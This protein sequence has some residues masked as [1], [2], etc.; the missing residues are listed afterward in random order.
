MAM[1]A[2]QSDDAGRVVVTGFR[3]AAGPGDFSRHVHPD[4]AQLMYAARGLMHVATPDGRWILPPGRA[5]WI[6]AGTEHGLEV[7]RHADLEILYFG[8]DTPSLPAWDGCAV[9]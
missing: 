7:R 6:A 3:T 2:S 5:L 1:T 4:R 9:V 8:I